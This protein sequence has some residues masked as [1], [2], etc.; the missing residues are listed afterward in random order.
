MEL[1]LEEQIRNIGKLNE[2]INGKKSVK[3]EFKGIPISYFPNNCIMRDSK[4]GEEL[5]YAPASNAYQYRS[6]E[7]ESL[8]GIDCESALQILEAAE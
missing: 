5:W 1:T 3:R 4:T 6:T 7:E 8:T 2:I